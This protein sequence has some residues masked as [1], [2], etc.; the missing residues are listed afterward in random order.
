MCNGDGRDRGFRATG[1]PD[2]AGIVPVVRDVLNGLRC[3][4]CNGHG[5]DAE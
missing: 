2:S 5:R 4:A 3:R 1:E